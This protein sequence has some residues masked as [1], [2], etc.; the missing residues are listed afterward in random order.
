MNQNILIA[1][2]VSLFTFLL[3][4]FVYPFT[5]TEVATFLFYKRAKGSLIFN[6]QNKVIGSELIGQN[7]AH[8]AYFFPRPSAAGNGYDGMASGGS[9]LGP[10][11]KA[12]VIR[13]QQRIQTIKKDNSEPIPLDL[14]TASASGLDP[15]ISPQ[16]AN[17][18]APRIALERNVS[19]ERVMSLIEDSIIPP[20]FNFLGKPRVNV[21]KL[22]LVLDQFFGPP[23]MAP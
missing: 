5:V 18:Q 7:F 8:P 1:F 22:N 23:V 9:N 13:I 11:S 10:T 2:K 21:L 16:A 12:L 20:Q 3:I 15:H 17:W 19:L 6:E 14:V 4:G